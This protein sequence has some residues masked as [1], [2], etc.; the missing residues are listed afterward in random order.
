MEGC[1]RHQVALFA[2]VS[3]SLI[4]K[5][6]YIYLA[7]SPTL[8]LG[9]VESKPVHSVENLVSSIPLFVYV[10][11]SLINK[12]NYIYIARSPSLLLVVIVVLLVPD[13]LSVEGCTRHQVALF[14]Y[15]RPS[16]IR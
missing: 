8:C 12:I 13:G 4:N 6:N 7:R 3:S 15:V 2:Y 14:A 5:I 9:H 10:K 1:T 16:L 11:S